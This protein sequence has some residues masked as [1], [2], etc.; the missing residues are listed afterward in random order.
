[1]GAASQSE[2]LKKSWIS[3]HPRFVIGVIL[4]GCLAPFINKAIHG[5]EMLF[6]WMAEW[7]QKHPTD[8]YGFQVNMYGST[9]PMW[10]G[11]YNPPLISYFLAG[12][13]AVFGWHEI[14]LHAAC[15]VVAFTAAAGIYALAKM[16]CDRPLL[17][18]VVAI[19]TPAFLVCSTTLTCDVLMLSFWIWALVCWE[20]GLASSEQSWWRFAGAGVLA[21]LA[22]LTKYSAVTLL[23]L[24]L[25]L[26]ILR[27]RRLGWWLLG[28][29]VPLAMVLGYEWLTARM[30]GRGLLFAAAGNVQ[31][32]GLEFPGGWKAKGVIGLAFA[33]GSLLPLLCYAPWLWRG[34]ALLA[35]GVCD[36]GDIAGD[37]SFRWQP[38]AAAPLAK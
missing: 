25:I 21:G 2:N 17:A 8:F 22:V 30:Y 19:F 38:W 13:A 7:I 36:F 1:M 35:M 12:V 29:A 26:S 37:M 20:R 33:G 14:V 6:I 3:E 28:L 18:T 31:T 23:P 10:V 16:W 27:T 15:L 34:R 9:I 32:S 4:V 5:D 24:L 11:N